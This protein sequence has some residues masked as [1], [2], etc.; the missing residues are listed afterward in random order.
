MHLCISIGSIEVW[1]EAEE[2]LK[3]ACLA[4]GHDFKINPGDGAFY[5]P[6]LD[7]KL[8]DSM[9]RIFDYELLL[10]VIILIEQVLTKVGMLLQSFQ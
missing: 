5:G 2:A 8:K 7:F 1:N 10:L 9:N 3:E 4:T 6:K